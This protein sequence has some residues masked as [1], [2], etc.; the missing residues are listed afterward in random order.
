LPKP[1][2]KPPKSFEAMMKEFSGRDRNNDIVVEPTG[3]I[4][5][6]EEGTGP[7]VKPKLKLS[8]SDKAA[9]TAADKD[10]VKTVRPKAAAS[11]L[12]THKAD[13]KTKGFLTTDYIIEGDTE[14]SIVIVKPT[15]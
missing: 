4:D 7:E 8:D 15:P 12:T 14:V 6:T 5:A 9:R 11:L 3:A 2:R 10:P 1:V 13:Q